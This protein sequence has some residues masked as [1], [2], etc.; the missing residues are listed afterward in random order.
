MTHEFLDESGWGWVWNCVSTGFLPYP[1]E[2]DEKEAGVTGKAV[3][4]GRIWEVA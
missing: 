1:Q 2:L 4:D 3:E